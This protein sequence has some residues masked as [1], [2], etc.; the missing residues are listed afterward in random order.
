[1]GETFAVEKAAGGGGGSVVS[2]KVIVSGMVGDPYCDLVGMVA[3]RRTGDPASA[4]SH[5][6]A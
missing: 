3:Q 2:A 4:F 6:R 5:D 1:M